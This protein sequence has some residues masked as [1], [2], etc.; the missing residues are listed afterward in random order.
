MAAPQI[1]TQYYHENDFYFGT[2]NSP[3][4]DEEMLAYVQ[5]SGKNG[6]PVDWPYIYH[7]SHIRA[8]V[9]RDLPIE[10]T[11]RVLEIGAECGTIT[12]I[13]AEKAADVDAVC[14]SL[15]RARINAVMN[16]DH[17]NIR[18]YA[19]DLTE[20]LTNL[21]NK[22][23]FV[24]M[25]GITEYA[26]ELMHS[27]HAL[28][29]MLQLA[30]AMLNKEG[31]LILAVPNRIGFKYLMGEA[32]EADG[33]YWGWPENEITGNCDNR[34][35]CGIRVF[36]K[37]EWVNELESLGFS[38][39]SFS[40]P[41]PDHRFTTQIFSDYF[42][43]KKGELN[44]N[45]D[46]YDRPGYVLCDEE[47]VF[48]S[49]VQNGAFPQ[50]SNAFLITAEKNPMTEN[51]KLQVEQTRV[52]LKFSNDRD[53]DRSVYTKLQA[54][55]SNNILV[56]K[57]ADSQAANS[58]LQHIS[59]VSQKLAAYYEAKN[60]AV[61]EV[62]PVSENELDVKFESGRTVE[63]IVDDTLEQQGWDAASQKIRDYFA[64]IFD[65]CK[66][67]PFSDT[68][69]FARAF[70]KGTADFFADACSLQISD[71]DMLMANMMI[72]SDGSY[73]LLDYEW[74][75]SFP[76]P[77]KF[78]KYRIL[79][80]Y[81]EGSLQRKNYAT[82]ET[83][84]Q[85]GISEKERTIFQ[86]MESSFQ[87]YVKGSRISLR[88]QY[89]EVTPGSYAVRDL[90]QTKDVLEIAN[91]IQI[92][93]AAKPEDISAGQVKTFEISEHRAT[94]VMKIPPK[95]KVVRIDPGERHCAVKIN[96]LFT[97]YLAQSDTTRMSGGKNWNR[98]AQYATNGKSI[99]NQ[100]IV[101][102]DEDPQILL[103]V[104]SGQYL[105]VDLEIRWISRDRIQLLE[106]RTIEELNHIFSAM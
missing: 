27:S 64:L 98:I 47:K 13:L 52:Y 58:F 97:S 82:S 45:R 9:I 56:R 29:R 86:T 76:I 50:L 91:E 74:T 93:W 49:I 92:F 77:V 70:G 99:G 24:V 61:N 104:R 8:N 100:V 37:T 73:C 71:I 3:E 12:G 4:L 10:K 26:P 6:F 53:P 16:Q 19:G 83:Y 102:P 69:E 39:C 31:R 90:F 42:L 21:D 89:P 25:V 7:F 65:D 105:Y 103:P 11:D 30:S 40:Y 67:I 55:D 62:S 68:E 79:H 44:N 32:A 22:Y 57:K 34:S 36:G 59:E 78:L 51:G 94:I 85:F 35:D 46:N 84:R 63:Q 60:I 33:S 80:Y 81:L 28:H 75:F 41:Y 72:R 54:I 20:I 17:D 18:I 66:M 101:F 2:F 5:N 14:F 43:P 1:L 96:Y 38:H 23:D 48:H 106:K 87:N 95:C 88:E 15:N